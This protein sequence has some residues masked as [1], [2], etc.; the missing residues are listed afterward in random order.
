VVTEYVVKRR[1]CCGCGKQ[2]SPPIPNVIEGGS[3]ERFGLR[4]MLLVVSLKMLGMSY[5]KIGSLLELLFNL[6]L[7]EAAMFHWVTAVAEAF[8]P[9]YEELKQEL[10]REA[11]IHGDETSSRIKGKNHWLWLQPTNLSIQSWRERPME[12]SSTIVA[13]RTHDMGDHSCESSEDNAPVLARGGRAGELA[14]DRAVTWAQTIGIA[15]SGVRVVP[16]ER[17]LWG[18]GCVEPVQSRPRRCPRVRW[19]DA[20][21]ETPRRTGSSTVTGIGMQTREDP[22]LIRTAIGMQKCQRWLLGRW[23]T[24]EAVVAM[25]PMITNGKSEGPL[26]YRGHGLMNG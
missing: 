3:N 10:R 1:Y 23:S 25:T 14:S 12:E 26:G 2:V 22:C 16:H 24:H 6:D 5:E 4:L 7:T 11:S 21:E 9:R 20:P 8:G 17:G 18:E 19:T 13:N 15:L